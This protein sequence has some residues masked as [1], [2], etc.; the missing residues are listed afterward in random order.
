MRGNMRPR[1]MAPNH[2]TRRGGFRGNGRMMNHHHIKQQHMLLPGDTMSRP[3]FRPAGPEIP[4]NQC[5]GQIFIDFNQ[6]MQK[7]EQ[8]Q[9][10]PPQSPPVTQ[11]QQSKLDSI[12]TSAPRQGIGIV[13]PQQHSQPASSP[14]P[15]IIHRQG[16]PLS[17]RP[18]KPRSVEQHRLFYPPPQQQR[19]PFVPPQFQPMQQI[20][21]RPPVFM[22]NQQQIFIPQQPH[23]MPPNPNPLPPPVMGNFPYGGPPGASRQGGVVPMRPQG[24]MEFNRFPDHGPPPQMWPEQGPGF[25]APPPQF[26]V[27]AP[28]FFPQNQQH[29]QMM[30]QFPAPMQQFP[31]DQRMVGPSYGVPQQQFQQPGPQPPSF[32]QSQHFDYR[33]ERFEYGRKDFREDRRYEQDSM[34]RV[35][36]RRPEDGYRIPAKV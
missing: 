14:R 27:M 30:N 6:P 24:Q 21:L 26:S 33:E 4:V 34:R 9:T 10:N 1:G 18:T 13:R 12:S 25:A 23:F 19:P 2:L 20:P 7:Q 8:D 22:P 11:H 15:G 35:P 3:E 17:S 31:N 29:P 5:S 32:S 28:G 36:K 16:N